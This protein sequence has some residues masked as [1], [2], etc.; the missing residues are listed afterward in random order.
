MRIKAKI[1]V[2]SYSNSDLVGYIGSDTDLSGASL[3]NYG[4]INFRKMIGN[5]SVDT[6]TVFEVFA[7]ETFITYA[8]IAS[9]YSQVASTINKQVSY[10]RNQVINDCL[11]R[12]QIQTTR[13]I[14]FPEGSVFIIEGIDKS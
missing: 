10:G 6:Y 5:N 8:E 11:R 2:D 7:D 14:G 12:V 13:S 9:H 1:P 4:L 3:N